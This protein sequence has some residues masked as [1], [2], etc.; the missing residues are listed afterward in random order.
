MCDHNTTAPVGVCIQAHFIINKCKTIGCYDFAI[1]YLDTRIQIP[2]ND[3][4]LNNVRIRIDRI[5]AGNRYVLPVGNHIFN[6]SARVDQHRITGT[7]CINSS[8]DGSIV[9]AA[10][11]LYGQSDSKDKVGQ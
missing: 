2:I 11:L 3:G 6:I 9:T 5:Q 10:I 4:V 8:L 7:G 1:T